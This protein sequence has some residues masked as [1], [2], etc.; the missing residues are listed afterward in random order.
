[1]WLKEKKQ[2]WSN[3]TSLL[4][5]TKHACAHKHRVR[6]STVVGNVQ[7]CEQSSN[8]C[9][10]YLSW[11]GRWPLVS[12]PPHH[13]TASAGTSGSEDA[14]P[15][16][17]WTIPW[18]DTELHSAAGSLQTQAPSLLYSVTARPRPRAALPSSCSAVKTFGRPMRGLK[19]L[20]G[21]GRAAVIQGCCPDHQSIIKQGEILPGICLAQPIRSSSCRF[22]RSQS[23]RRVHRP[24]SLDDS[25]RLAT[26]GAGSISSKSEMMVFTKK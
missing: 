23:D 4:D 2:M 1:M 3:E 8:V 21:R 12:L 15:H 18:L 13:S 19:S 5:L 9:G 6:V 17:D 24:L 10:V 7:Q 20:R 16:T 14:E 11:R 26:R 22:N 25:C